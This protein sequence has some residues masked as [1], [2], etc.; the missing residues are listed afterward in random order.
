ME[1]INDRMTHPVLSIEQDK[2]VKNAAEIIYSNK[3]GSL[4]VTE[5]GNYIGIITKTDLMT[6]VLIKNLDAKTIKV[7]EVMSSPLYTIDSGESLATARETLREKSVRHLTV[8]RNDEVVGILSIKD[9]QQYP[10]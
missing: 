1:T 6:R 9:L 3:I 8:T 2:T 4:L 10:S 7:S 5:N